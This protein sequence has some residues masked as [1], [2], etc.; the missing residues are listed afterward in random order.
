MI[1]KDTGKVLS[2]EIVENVI[3]NTGKER[4][5]KLLKGESAITFDTI[6]IGTG[7]T[8]AGASDTTLETEDQRAVASLSYEASYK[9]IFEK[10]FSFVASGTTAITE[11]GAFDNS[12]VESG[13]VMLNRATFSAKNVD[14]DT[15]LYV[16]L[17]IT[18][19]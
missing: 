10:T 12:G 6:A 9:A 16:K 17:T 11:A 5:A 19:A 14:P 18:I 2:T 15:D 13:S 8:G 1:D 4:I 3:V 7:V